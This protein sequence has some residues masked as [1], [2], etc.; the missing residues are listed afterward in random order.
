LGLVVSLSLV[1]FLIIL[2]KNSIRE[3]QVTA[4]IG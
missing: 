2:R 3:Q 1:G 4:K